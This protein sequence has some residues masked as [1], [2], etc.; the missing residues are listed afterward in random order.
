MS[1]NDRDSR[2]AE[3]SSLGAGAEPRG[4]DPLVRA[5]EEAPLEDEEISPEEE[6]AVQEAREELAA[7]APTVSLEKIKREFGLS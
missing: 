4:V 5:L 6:A 7:G 3:D 1:S 2:R